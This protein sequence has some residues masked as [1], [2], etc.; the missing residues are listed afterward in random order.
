MKNRKSTAAILSTIPAVAFVA[1]VAGPSSAAAGTTIDSSAHAGAFQLG[2]YS[3]KT[4]DGCYVRPNG[5]GSY[6]VPAGTEVNFGM[7]GYRRGNAQGSLSS[8]WYSTDETNDGLPLYILGWFWWINGA[9]N[10]AM[11]S[12][13]TL[14][15]WTGQNPPD[16]PLYPNWNTNTSTGGIFVFPHTF[17]KKNQTENVIGAVYPVQAGQQY[18]AAVVDWD[19][20]VASP[21]YQPSCY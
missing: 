20:R 5:D 2:R 9:V 6:T 8:E 7:Y 1:V 18:Q 11:Y 4:E 15:D 19:V 16:D 21:S 10:P 3:V 17:T 13:Q 12:D 14:Y